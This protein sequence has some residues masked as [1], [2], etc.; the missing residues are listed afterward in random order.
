MCSHTPG[1]TSTPDPTGERSMRSSEKQAQWV[2]WAWSRWGTVM[3]C[4]H[5]VCPDA[6]AGG[7]PEWVCPCVSYSGLT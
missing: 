7:L 6:G 4:V 2:R 1:T 5:V 3:G